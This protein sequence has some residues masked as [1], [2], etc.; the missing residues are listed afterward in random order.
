MKNTKKITYL[1]PLLTFMLL[2]GCSFSNESKPNNDS[3]QQPS[4]SEFD[5]SKYLDPNYKPSFDNI[6]EV[7]YYAYFKKFSPYY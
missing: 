6:C 5:L 7:S 2:P 3:N 4:E 1:L